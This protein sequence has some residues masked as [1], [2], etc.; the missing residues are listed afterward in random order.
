MEEIKRKYELAKAHGFASYAA[1]R[2]ASTSLWIKDERG[3]DW[4][5]AVDPR[6]RWFVWRDWVQ[7]AAIEPADEH[8]VGA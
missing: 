6:G 4:F 5:V 2:A 3:A 1:L 7:S 8:L